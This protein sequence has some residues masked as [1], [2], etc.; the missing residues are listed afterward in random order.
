METEKK[1]M[2]RNEMDAEK[3][4]SFVTALR[5]ERGLTQKQLAERLYVSNK[6]VS[7][8][9][10]G[11]GMPDIS[12]LEPLAE[13]LEVSVSELLR[14]KRQTPDWAEV[15][16]LTDAELCRLF[17]KPPEASPQEKEALKRIR[18]RRAKWYFLGLG[19][20]AA[21]MAL[22][23]ALGGKLGISMFDRLL[24]MLTTIPLVLFLGIW[25]FFFM[26]E[27]LPLL[28][29]KM[30][31]STYSDGFFRFEMAGM[32]F[33]NR[34]WPHITKALRTFCF[35][36]PVC[37]PAVYVPV[38]LLVPDFLWLFGRIFVLLGLVL[39]GLFIPVAVLGKKYE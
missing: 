3:F 24:D 22:L 21:E 4:G 32:A 9:E 38:R 35:L 30:R 37:W 33:N 7:K 27:R 14:G 25:P 23:F 6:A 16:K 31:I 15:E 8:W 17:K 19:L 1:D 10:T 36:M 12:L 39:G 5:R 2:G 34:N 13:V 11:Q 28:Y 29:D 20:S 18:K 26:P